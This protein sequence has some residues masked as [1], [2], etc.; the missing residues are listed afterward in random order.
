MRDKI[1]L[2]ITLTVVLLLTLVIY[3][4][5]DA[6][7]GPAT[8]AEA[9]EEAINNGRHIYAKYCI[10]CHG[11]KGEGCIGPALNRD[12][13]RAEKNGAPNPAF[14]SDSTS[15]ITKVVTR[16]R[17]SNQPGVQMPAWG[18]AEGGALTPQEIANVVTFIQY[19]D[20]D[21]VL[22]EADSA[23]GLDKDFPPFAETGYQGGN[24]DAAKAGAARVKTL[25]LAKGCLTCHQLG[26]V[27][28][29]VA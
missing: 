1:I 5:V 11:P 28:G 14:D 13:W 4:G 22:E 6:Q 2:G 26:G 17:P 29:R 16:G 3:L 23:V 21:G 12:A 20:W 9:R 7:R 27:G 18:E 10:Q 25:M 19:G 24:L 8:L 15:F